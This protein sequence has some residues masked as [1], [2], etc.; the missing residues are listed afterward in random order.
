MG[1]RPPSGTSRP[2]HRP[3]TGRVWR[4]RSQLGLALDVYA[5]AHD[6]KCD[7]DVLSDDECK[8]GRNRAEAN[9]P[10]RNQNGEQSPPR[11]PEAGMQLEAVVVVYGNSKRRRRRG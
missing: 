6:K 9:E 8:N 3:C 1:L 10:A 4:C 2:E 7:E 5:E 11:Q